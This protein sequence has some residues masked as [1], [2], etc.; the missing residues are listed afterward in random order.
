MCVLKIKFLPS[1]VQKLS[2]EQTDRQTD[3]QTDRQTDRL[4]W[5]YYLPHTRM[6]KILQTVLLLGTWMCLSWITC[7]NSCIMQLK[8]IKAP[9]VFKSSFLLHCHLSFLTSQ[10]IVYI[11]SNWS[12]WFHIL[13][14]YIIINYQNWLM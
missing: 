4:N 14:H 5:N 13:R 2:S 1:V 12:I 7:M 9:V 10:K 6:I 3:G 11:F 8:S